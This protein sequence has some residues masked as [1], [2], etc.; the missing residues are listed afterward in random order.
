[1]EQAKSA[2]K[3][4]QTTVTESIKDLIG[5]DKEDKSNEQNSS[6][7]TDKLTSSESN[8]TSKASKPRG[9]GPKLISIRD[10]PM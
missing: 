2:L 9:S 7:I 8:V 6:V 10:I 1:M 4:I 3:T 5:G